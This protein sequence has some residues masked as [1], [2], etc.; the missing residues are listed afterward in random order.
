MV[1]R[2]GTGVDA[3]GHVVLASADS[4]A[5]TSLRRRSTSRLDRYRTGRE[6]RRQVPRGSLGD[7]SAPAGRPDPVQLIIESHKGRLDR[8]IP[9]RVGRAAAQAR[10]RTSDRALPKFTSE[11]DGQRRIVEDPPLVTR[12]NYAE[13]DQIARGLDEYLGTLARTGGGPWAGTR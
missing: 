7:W 10:G 8:L 1:Q 5:F 6:L 13:A 11:R 2:T 3:R 9:V 4:D 12:I